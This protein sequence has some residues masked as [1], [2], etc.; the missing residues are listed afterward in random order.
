MAT[1]SDNVQREIQEG[2]KLP[3]KLPKEIKVTVF[4]VHLKELNL[5]LVG[6]TSLFGAVLRERI[7]LI[8]Q[9]TNCR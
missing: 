5:L 3:K 2:K 8:H 7:A 4:N 9:I 1:K 6:E